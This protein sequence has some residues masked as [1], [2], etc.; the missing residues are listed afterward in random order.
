MHAGRTP[1]TARRR[2]PTAALAAGALAAALTACGSGTDGGVDKTRP[3]ASG[4]APAAAASESPA[5]A[6]PSPE[7]E[8]APAPEDRDG[9]PAERGGPKTSRVQAVATAEQSVAGGRVSDVALESDEGTRVW[10]VDVMTAEPRVHNVKV[11][12]GTGALLGSRADRMPE[13]AR[14]HLAA[15]L[16]KLDAAAVDRETAVRTAL[17]EAGGGFVSRVSIQGT[18]T[19]P[20]WQVQVTDGTVRHDIEV[21]ARSGAVGAH[22]RHEKDEGRETNETNEKGGKDEKGVAAAERGG[23]GAGERGGATADRGRPSAEEIRER[24]GDFGREFYDWSRNVPR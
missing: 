17:A 18:Q 5:P 23:S 1:T 12:A 19:A 11:D 14:R 20:L 24:S 6:S 22:D 16:A 21:D 15:P 10:R 7:A 9:G 4:A 2:L 3:A 8:G 13:R